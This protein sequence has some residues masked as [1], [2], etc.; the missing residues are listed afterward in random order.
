MNQSY[1]IVTK[2]SILIDGGRHIQFI[3][4]VRFTILRNNKATMITR[5]IAE[6]KRASIRYAI[7]ITIGITSAE[8]SYI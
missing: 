3:L 4:T 1:I 7:D 6:A 5:V 8:T 2:L